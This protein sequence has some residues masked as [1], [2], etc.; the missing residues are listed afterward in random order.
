MDSRCSSWVMRPTITCRVI[1]IPRIVCSVVGPLVGQWRTL[2]RLPLLRSLNAHPLRRPALPRSAFSSFISH[3]F[4]DLPPPPKRILPRLDLLPAPAASQRVPQK[5]ARSAA[6]ASRSGKIRWRINIR[7]RR[8]S[9]RRA[10]RHI[11]VHVGS[12]SCAS[13]EQ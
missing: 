10:P 12:A 4:A 3:T 1:Q 13:D 2:R 7:A 5:D 11:R 8:R 9:C 6:F